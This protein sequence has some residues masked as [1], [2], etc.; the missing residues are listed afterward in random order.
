MRCFQT[1][2]EAKEYALCFANANSHRAGNRHTMATEFDPIE[3]H[4]LRVERYEA[5]QAYR[6]HYKKIMETIV[7]FDRYPSP[8]SGGS[9]F[10]IEA[11]LE[12]VPEI[13]KK[14]LMYFRHELPKVLEKRTQDVIE[15]ERQRSL[16][17]I[18]K[19]EEREDT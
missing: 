4:K 7:N 9:A 8:S 19:N 17:F 1:I 12:A 14:Q 6:K 2:E 10:L 13:T 5:Y 15:M 16:D 3:D 11:I 18:R